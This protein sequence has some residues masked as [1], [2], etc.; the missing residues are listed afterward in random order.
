MYSQIQHK[1]N[2]DNLS[3]GIFIESGLISGAEKRALKICYA[4]NS[5]DIP[6]K[7][8]ITKQLFD[9]FC[10][11]EYKKYLE[12]YVVLDDNWI[13]RMR[14]KKNSK[15]LRKYSGFNRFINSLYRSKVKRIINANDISILH[16]FMASDLNLFKGLIKDYCISTIFE[17]TSPD[18]AEKIEKS[19]KSYLESFSYFNAVSDSVYLK[20]AKLIPDCKLYR[21]PI[22]FFSPAEYVVNHERIFERKEKNIVFAHR[23][24]PRKNGFLFSKVIKEFLKKNK[25]WTVKILGNG[26]ESEAINDLLSEEIFAG[27]VTTGYHTKI[28][29]ELEKSQIFVSIIE[30]D[31]YP[32][33]SVLEAMYTGNALLLSDRGFTKERFWDGNGILCDVRFDDVLEKLIELT[34]DESRLE[35][36]G[37]KSIEMLKAK[38]DSSI[39][40]EYVQKMYK[41]VSQSH[42]MQD[43]Q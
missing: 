31:N 4:L 30:P 10:N 37:R 38:Y 25:N 34:S 21:A 20:S 29:S 27:L 36:Y 11:T 3:Y 22:P 17:I 28:I 8:L 1:K 43:E 39:Y 23:L 6:C 2:A 5:K 33:Q 24:I 26:P 15:I 9:L 40:L 16:V 35:A 32:S 18:Y 12:N 7:L 41:S 19:N 14:N 42:T 13:G